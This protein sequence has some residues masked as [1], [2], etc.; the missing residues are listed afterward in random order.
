MNSSGSQ[1]CPP[2]VCT[3]YCVFVGEVPCYKIV[4]EMNG[5][6]SSFHT[7]TRLESAVARHGL[8]T[9]PP[10]ETHSLT[11]ASFHSHQPHRV[12]NHNPSKTH[13]RVKVHQ[14]K[15]SNSGPGV[16]IHRTPPHHPKC[17]LYQFKMLSSLHTDAEIKGLAAFCWLHQ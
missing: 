17:Q 6:I 4:L 7:H 13:I 14:S 8:Y 10:L 15:L 11:D 12:N 3:L 5:T 9:Q 16:C 2:I 1:E